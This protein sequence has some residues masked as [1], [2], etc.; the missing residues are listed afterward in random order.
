MKKLVLLYASLLA[1]GSSFAQQETAR[2]VSVTPNLQQVTVARQVCGNETIAAAPSQKSGAGAIMGGIAGGAIGNSVGQGSGRAAAT[3]IGL[4]G[5]A[6]L[7]DK[8]EGSSDQPAKIV[9]RCSTQNVL[10]NRIANYTVVYEFGG[11][12]YTVQMPYD[13]GA[14]IKLQLTPIG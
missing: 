11:K 1:S 5:G 2:V 3:M 8:I 13:P 12:Q 4:V 9:Q 6:I 14:S 10:E 7:G